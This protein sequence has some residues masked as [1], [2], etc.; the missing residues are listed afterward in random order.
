MLANGRISEKSYRDYRI[1]QRIIPEPLDRIAVY[2]VQTECYARRFRELGVPGERIFVTGTMKLDNIPAQPDPEEDE[3]LRRVFRIAPDDRVLIGGST[4]PGEDETLLRIYRGL[5]RTHPGARLILVPRHPERLA[6]VADSIRAAGFPVER[7][8]ALDRDVA[9]E[10]SRDAVILVD[11]MGELARIYGVADV[12][13]VGGSLVPHGGQNMMEP[14][15]LG[16]PVLF[17][18]HVENF[19][20]TVDVLR[21]GRGAVLVNDESQLETEITRLFEDVSAAREMGRRAREAVL[22]H[23]GATGR[24]LAVFRDV[25]A[26]WHPGENRRESGTT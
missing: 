18:P 9:R 22:A 8:T 5:R 24:M 17:G 16:K 7:K 25:L 15:G 21:D 20:E 13:F 4:H 11:T 10:I 19:Q 3:R 1:L 2:C 12:V 6:A 23:R 14:A 26:A